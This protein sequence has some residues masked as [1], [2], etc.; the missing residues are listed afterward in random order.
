MEKI[1][2]NRHK[3]YLDNVMF[4]N[5]ADSSV[6][7]SWLSSY[8]ETNNNIRTVQSESSG[9]KLTRFQIWNWSERHLLI[10]CIDQ[11]A[12]GFVVNYVNK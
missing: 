11:I 10:F 1:R 6:L 7:T 12:P 8:I 2:N 3:I 5:L 9:V 4:K